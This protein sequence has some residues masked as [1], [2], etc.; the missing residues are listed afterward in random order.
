MEYRC[1]LQFTDIIHIS[2]QYVGFSHE[3]SAPISKDA[4]IIEEE[5]VL[6]F[7]ISE[8]YPAHHRP[9]SPWKIHA[10]LGG[11]S[12]LDKSGEFQIL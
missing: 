11:S 10:W 7:V 3:T 12:L 6:W 9:A 5:A 1:I 4:S 2:Q 8:N